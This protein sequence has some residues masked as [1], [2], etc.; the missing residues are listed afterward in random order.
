MRVSTQST[1]LS[2]QSTPLQ[3]VPQRRS[4]VTSGA[5]PPP[6]PPSGCCVSSA[7]QRRPRRHCP[8]ARAAPICRRQGRRRR[9]RRHGRRRRRWR[10]PPASPT[11]GCASSCKTVADTPASSRSSC[12]TGTVR[13]PAAALRAEPRGEAVRRDGKRGR[14]ARARERR[15]ARR[16]VRGGRVRR[17]GRL[18]V[19]RRRRPP[20]RAAP[21]AA[22]SARES[23][24]ALVWGLPRGVRC[25]DGE[26]YYGMYKAGDAHGLGVYAYANGDVYSGSFRRGEKDGF[27]Q[28]PLPPCR[29]GRG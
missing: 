8:S 3:R 27:G 23:A 16:P 4:L 7:R 11:R 17:A 14:G 2:P 15:P 18:H 28:R 1:Q 22:S 19:R 13:A 21:S 10:V 6:P 20:I 29:C 9:R 25:A 26:A 12:R 24:D 5:F